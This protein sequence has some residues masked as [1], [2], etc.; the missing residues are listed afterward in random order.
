M[1]EEFLWGISRG[2]SGTGE[3]TSDSIDTLSSATVLNWEAS[4][5]GGLRQDAFLI[6]Q[7]I[8]CFLVKNNAKIIIES[9]IIVI[10]PASHYD[11]ELNCN[12]LRPGMVL[13]RK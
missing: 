8:D 7:D 4:T 13:S 6:G 2:R 5:A 9:R 3:N 12:V 10:Y 11:S 1:W